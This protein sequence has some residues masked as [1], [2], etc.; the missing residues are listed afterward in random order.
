MFIEKQK[1]GCRL[2]II[3]LLYES[4]LLYKNVSAFISTKSQQIMILSIL[5]FQITDLLTFVI[6]INYFLLQSEIHRK[7]TLHQTHLRRKI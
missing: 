1:N 6:V 4:C 7:F 3:V 5:L 2:Y